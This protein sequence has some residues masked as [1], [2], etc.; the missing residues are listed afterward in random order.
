M[1]GTLSLGEK[2][3]ELDAPRTLLARDVGSA[4]GDDGQNAQEKKIAPGSP[5]TVGG[6][7]HAR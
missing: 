5:T 6:A 3:A 2:L 4:Y 1:M 7:G